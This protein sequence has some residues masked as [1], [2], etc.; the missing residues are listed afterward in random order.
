MFSTSQP[1]SDRTRAPH[2]PPPS[3]STSHDEVVVD[4]VPISRI[5]PGES[6]NE[7]DLDNL[8]TLIP[9]SVLAGIVNQPMPKKVSRRLRGLAPGVIPPAVPKSKGGPPRHVPFENMNLVDEEKIQSDSDD[10]D[11]LP[12]G[13]V[14]A[15]PFIPDLTPDELESIAAGV[16]ITNNEET[17]SDA[18]ILE[19]AFARARKGK[20][21]RIADEEEETPP[22]RSQRRRGN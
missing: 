11:Y 22:R 18:E 20:G 17:G 4:A 7:L 10:E 16:D 15:S 2:L 13:T 9:T 5:L 1:T 3:S 19:A 12:P 8:P 6:G 14:K 21:K